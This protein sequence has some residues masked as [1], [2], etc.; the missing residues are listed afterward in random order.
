MLT[1]YTIP[2]RGRSEN[3]IIAY[4]IILEVPNDNIDRRT[5]LL[6]HHEFPRFAFSASPPDGSTDRGR[7]AE[8]DAA[9]LWQHSVQPDC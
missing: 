1:T 3:V 6:S 7:G 5:A 8:H 9:V 2:E 4:L